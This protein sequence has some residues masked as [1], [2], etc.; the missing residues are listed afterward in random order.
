MMQTAPPS[1]LPLGGD[2]GLYLPP[3]TASRL[4]KRASADG[5]GS[6]HTTDAELEDNVE[7]IQL[8]RSVR[9]GST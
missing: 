6:E 5:G 9:R 1:Q 2:A 3:R 8:R 4:F 7:M